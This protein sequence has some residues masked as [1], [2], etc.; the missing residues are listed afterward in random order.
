M[1]ASEIISRYIDSQKITVKFRR[2][3]E[4]DIARNGPQG[5]PELIQT[6]YGDEKG[7]LELAQLRADLMKTQAEADEAA[8]SAVRDRAAAQR[9]IGSLGR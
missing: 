1:R 8:A 4:N 9:T 2:E 5:S 3:L 6:M 7:D